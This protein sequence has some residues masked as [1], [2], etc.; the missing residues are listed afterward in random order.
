M[1]QRS[2]ALPAVIAGAF[3]RVRQ[4]PRVRAGLNTSQFDGPISGFR[5]SSEMARDFERRDGVN[6]SSPPW[7]ETLVASTKPTSIKDENHD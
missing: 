6:R 3:P 2:E 4:T 1:L 5:K 7:T